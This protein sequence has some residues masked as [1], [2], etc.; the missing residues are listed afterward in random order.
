M[1][2]LDLR[3][4]WL[5]DKTENKELRVLKEGTQ[6][7]WADYRRQGF[8]QR[9]HRR[10]CAADARGILPSRSCSSG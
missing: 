2:R 5:Q 8:G 6:T 10:A 7:N 3:E 9:L 4:L 1:K